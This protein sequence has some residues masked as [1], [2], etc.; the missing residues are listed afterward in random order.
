MTYKELIVEILQQ[1]KE[2]LTSGQI[3]A[4]ACEIGLGKK[5]SS[6]GK[7]PEIFCTILIKATINSFLLSLKLVSIFQI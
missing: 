7:T 1:A 4:R 5:L 2:P 3:W 6:L